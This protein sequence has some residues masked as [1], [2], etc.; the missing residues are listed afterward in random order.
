[1]KIANNTIV[2]IEYTLKNKEGTVL[3]SS[4]GK[5]PLEYMHGQ[6]MLIPGLEKE[7]ED[8]KAGEKLAVTVA[9]ENAYGEYSEKMVFDVPKSQFDEN[10]KIE[11]GM[12]FEA[13][14][15]EGTQIVTVKKVLDDAVTIDANHELAGQTL[16]FDV[17]IKTVREAT[18][19]EID[20][21]NN[22]TENDCT[23][24]CD[25]CPSDC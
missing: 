6:G 19:K 23:S 17:E 10:A 20:M 25:T 1:M 22:T 5:M 4:E 3:D 7:L 14:G 2:T 11:A 16:F 21:L 13:G 24:C 9:P 18:K 8:K 15:A 12:K